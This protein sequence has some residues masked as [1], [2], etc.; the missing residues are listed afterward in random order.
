[1]PT[2]TFI[3]RKTQN[4]ITEMM[5]IS[6][7]EAFLDVYQDWDVKPAAPYIGDV[8]RQGLKKPSEGFRDILRTVKKRHKGGSRQDNT[9]GINTF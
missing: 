2:Y 8:V 5:T 3:N 4:E 1:M 9:R 7:M 6:E